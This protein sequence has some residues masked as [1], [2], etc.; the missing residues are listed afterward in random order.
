MAII[1]EAGT[2]CNNTIAHGGQDTEQNM[3]TNE[4]IDRDQQTVRKRKRK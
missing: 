1:A 3:F 2:Q 4:L